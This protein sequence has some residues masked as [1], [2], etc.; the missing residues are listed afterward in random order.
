MSN[1]PLNTMIYKRCESCCRKCR[2]CLQFEKI[3]EQIDLEERSLLERQ[4]EADKEKRGN[5]R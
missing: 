3:L 4:R 2:Q 5:E 1:S